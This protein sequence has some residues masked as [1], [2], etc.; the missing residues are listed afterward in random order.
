MMETGKIE[1]EVAKIRQEA[2]DVLERV[3]NSNSFTANADGID[4]TG[5]LIAAAGRKHG[6]DFRQM[7]V[8][9]EPAGR[10]HLFYDG[11][12]GGALAPYY[13]VLGHFDTVHE[14]D[15]PFNRLRAENNRLYGPGVL[16]MKAGLLAALYAIVVVKAATG[17][18]N[19]PVKI[20]FNCDE[21]TGSRDSGKLI[22]QQMTDAAAAFV[23]E[24]RR[25]ADHALVT[26]R[27]GIVMG[28]LQVHGKAAHAGEEPEKG[29]SAI[30]EAAAKILK[31]QQ[32]NDPHS[33]TQVNVGT[34]SGGTVANQI[35]DFCHAQI[36]IR[37]NTDAARDQV[38]RQI[39]DI[40]QTVTTPGTR[41]AYELVQA[42]PPFVQTAAAKRLLGLY[43]QAAGQ[44]GLKLSE[45]SAGGG[46]DANL[47]AALGVPTLDGL[48]PEGDGAH[49]GEEYIVGQSF[50]ESIQVFSLFFAR[51]ILNSKQTRKE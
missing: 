37:F 15:S 35:P 5:R 21:E 48:G 30:A 42:R 32:L 19:L 16:D 22:E 50:L 17:I 9:G 41:T 25:E 8:A 40:M 14:P 36:D 47:T 33:G 29:A 20:L 4:Q 2:F 28:S 31:L 23:F 1:K 51:L 45:R 12:P 46:S 7:P 39:Q 18:D 38:T 44:F 49:T 10:Y 3:V 27:K 13:T 24:G 34:V 6:I 11:S 43:L 26:S